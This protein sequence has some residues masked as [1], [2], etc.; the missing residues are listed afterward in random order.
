[1]IGTGYVG[2]VS[3]ACFA[4]AAHCQVVCVDSNVG[5][6]EALERGEMPIYEPELGELVQRNVAAGRLRFSTDLPNSVQQ[7]QVVFIAVGTPSRRGDGHADLSYVF[8]AAEAI[9]RSLRSPGFTLVVNKSTVP[10]GTARRVRELV[11]RNAAPGARFEV[12]SNPEFLRQGTAVRD[13]MHPERVVIGVPSDR[14]PAAVAQFAPGDG[15]HAHR[16]LDPDQGSHFD[17]KECARMLMA[18][19]YGP[20]ARAKQVPILFTNVEEAELIKYAANAFLAMKLEFANEIADLCE[21]AG[22]DISAVTHA[23]GLDGRIGAD[24]LQAGPGFGGSCL[25]KDTRALA[26]I[27]QEFWRPC[28]LVETVIEGNEA[29]KRRIAQRIALAAVAERAD[30]NQVYGRC[31]GILGLTFK[32]HT[33]DIR[34]S[35]A[36][37]IVRELVELGARVRA[38][39]PRVSHREVRQ[40]LGDEIELV[41]SVHE[42]AAGAD[43]LA[44]LTEWPEFRET[45]AAL[46]PQ[47]LDKLMRQRVLFDARN[48]WRPVDWQGSGFTYHSIGRPT[49][50][51]T[52][53]ETVEKA[54]L[55]T[56]PG[57]VHR[58]R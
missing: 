46:G 6:I 23:I 17:A 31:I 35:P 49:L 36:I 8:R 55:D 7:A 51:A 40:A 53:D 41:Q 15:D 27:A 28:R 2:L 52:A 20:I 12:V 9:G 33:D 1:M 34:D 37:F 19:L 56:S 14:E 21:V 47:G 45:C 42:A 50:Y 43:V 58:F 5:K 26:R 30:M 11:A 24:Y 25:P 18:K 38:Y 3:G 13:F 48:L 44:V 57:A 10:V 16:A 4:D 54:A 29:R 39:D 22:A 32:A